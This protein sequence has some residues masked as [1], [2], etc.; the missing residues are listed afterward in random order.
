MDDFPSFA[1]NAFAALLNTLSLLACLLF[2]ACIAIFY[3]GRRGRPLVAA[4]FPSIPLI[5]ASVCAQVLPAVLI[6][7]SGFNEIATEKTSGAIAVSNFVIKSQQFLLWRV[8]EAAVCILIVALVQAVRIARALDAGLAPAQDQESAGPALNWS[9]AIL[10]FL[11]IVSTAYLVWGC[12]DINNLVAL[13]VDPTKMAEANA[14][15]GNMDMA[16]VSSYISRHLIFFA[17]ASLNVALGS[18]ALAIHSVEDDRP[19]RYDVPVSALLTL[20]VLGLC[21]ANIARSV[22]TIN[23]LRCQMISRGGIPPSWK[24]G[25]IPFVELESGSLYTDPMGTQSDHSSGSELH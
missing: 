7:R 13:L 25:L 14:R 6:L 17:A 22:R 12:S 18:L 15:M 16:A 19:R 9:T 4:L 2:C 24:V 8:V 3:S 1:G 20:V 11:A 21:G 5:L 10:V 23:Y